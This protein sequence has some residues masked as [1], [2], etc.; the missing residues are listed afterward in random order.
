MP[1]LAYR[2]RFPIDH[3][4]A[5]QHG[6]RTVSSNL[7]LSCLRCNSFKG[8]NIASVDPVTGELVRLF[9]PRQDAWNAHFRWRGARVIG[10]TPIGRA[11]IRVLNI[12]DPDAA[13]VRRA[14][15]DEGVFPC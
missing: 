4:I 7:C 2:F 8:P 14:L 5:K 1:Q 9:H 10:L 12:N 6:G 3:I 15:M 13:R 11:T